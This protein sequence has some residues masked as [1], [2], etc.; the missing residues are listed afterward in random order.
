MKL[1][2]G[3]LKIGSLAVLVA[4]MSFG[5]F[6]KESAQSIVESGYVQSKLIEECDQH[7]HTIVIYDAKDEVVLEKSY[8]QDELD[9]TTR[10]MLYK[11]DFL[12]EIGNTSIFRLK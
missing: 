6:A 2:N 9:A 5:S 7:D 4:G 8:K 12:F 1:V 10:G 3:I 11:S